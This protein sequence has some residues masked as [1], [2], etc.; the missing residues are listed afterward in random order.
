MVNVS[1]SNNQANIPVGFDKDIIQAVRYDAVVQKTV[2]ME[3]WNKG[4]GQTIWKNRT[5]NWEKS[6]KYP[7]TQ[8][9]PTAYVQTS[10]PLFIDTFEVAALLLEDFGKLF[11]PDNILAD[12]AK[13]MGY[14]LS[15]AVETALTNLYQSFSA[16][17]PGTVSGV[18]LT[19][20]D[21]TTAS[22]M[23]RVGGVKPDS[24]KVFTVISPWQTAVF[25]N[26]QMFTD[27]NFAGSKG[28]NNFEKSMLTQTAVA[29]TTLV[30]SMLLRA[31][32]ANS[33]DM[34]MYS[35]E[36]IRMA[37]AEAPKYFSSYYGP[38]VGEFQGYKQAYGYTRSYRTVET[39]GS[40]SLT[41]AWAAYAPG[42]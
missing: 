16:Q 18:P 20:E 29:G 41:D 21:L 42:V 31:P 14:A 7:N 26:T 33:H 23:L 1:V 12:H 38:D 25:K 5:V 28:Q 17:V 10:E 8:V 6:F 15:R 3:K 32:S 13:S 22:R 4:M 2:T 19:Y 35:A 37:F 40:S 36:A 9:T 30:E 39:P 34:A 27:W 24:E 11:I